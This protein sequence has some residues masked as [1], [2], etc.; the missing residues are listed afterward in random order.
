MLKAPKSGGSNSDFP[1]QEPLDS[2]SYNGRL[3][4]A[5]GFGLQ[6][7]R[8]YKGQE[9]KPAYEIY[10]TYELSDEFIVDEEGKELSD[11]PRWVSETMPLYSLDS[12]KAKSTQR[13]LAMDPDKEHDGDFSK[14]I[15]SPASI[16]IVQNMGKD[17]DGNKKIYENISFISPVR[18]KT[19]KQMPELVN[20]PKVFDPDDPDMEVFFSL[21]E[22]M[23]EKIK[24]NLKFDGSA[25][26]KAIKS[27]K[28]KPEKEEPDQ[29][30]E[31]VDVDEED[32]DDVPW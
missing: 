1:K 13:Y 30:P 14:L 29:E 4:Q 9:K 28:G 12:E 32:E 15:S 6:K 25:L 10:L 23:Q 21:P 17:R 7:Q 27:H 11:K 20:P 16:T 31:D 18:P 8:P 2:G 3:V 26:D 19:A 24:S 22:W 5:I